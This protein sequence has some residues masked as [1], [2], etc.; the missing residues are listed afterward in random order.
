MRLSE[1][2]A[3]GEP[4]RCAARR[5]RGRRDPRALASRLLGV[6]LAVA[7]AALGSGARAQP[8]PASAAAGAAHRAGVG[9]NL[10]GWAYFSPDF[11]LI[12]QFKRSSG[13]LTQCEPSRDARCRDFAP[14]A[15]PWDT[16]EQARLE[17]DAQ[18]WPRRL[19]AA[20]DPAT[21]FRSV[22]VLL[23][24]GN[25]RTHPK[26]RYVV[27][28][29]GKG[30]LVHDLAGRKIERESRPGRDVVEVSDQ[31]DGG[32]RIAITA[33]DPKDPLR[34][35]RVVPPGGVCQKAPERYVESAAGCEPRAD[36]AFVPFD[37][38]PVDRLWHPRFVQ[39]LRGFRVL[40]FMDWGQTNS[41][42]LQH[43]ADRP[44]PDDAHWSGPAGVPLEAML[45]LSRATAAD[46]W[47]N[48]PMR[49]SDDYVRGF[50]RLLR[51]RLPPGRV[52]I[53]E[54]ANEP[55]N[56]AFPVAAWMRQQALARW[57]GAAARAGGED[58]LAVNWY[59][60]RSARLCQMV[61]AEWG[62]Q[63]APVRCV[64]NGHAAN[65]DQLRQMLACPQAAAELG[66]PCAK[67]VD[68]LAVAPYFGGYLG[69]P[70]IRP[71][72]RG[73]T[74]DADGGLGRLFQ[75]LLAEDDRR[76]PVR[77]PLQ[78]LHRDAPAGGALAQSHAWMRS[79]KA[80]ADAFGLPLWAYE[81]GQHL[82]MPPGVDDPAWLALIT[83]ANRDPRMARAYERSLAD[84][85]AAGGQL[86]VW[87]NH[88]AT[89][90]RWGAW[91]L[92]ETPF[93]E[94]AVKWQ[95][96]RAMRDQLACWWPRCDE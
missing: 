48:L 32:W 57:P 8:A 65:P 12:D 14:G 60:W 39:D 1:G 83:A 64:L 26:G 42:P 90:S 76:A 87:F 52:A 19:P 55:W 68:A 95:A 38:W 11:P 61:K 21:R 17:L 9:L 28:Y 96:V 24:N 27:T 16:R 71:L 20:D 69:E 34:N 13:W 18:G 77:P 43:W 94:A 88:M 7:L 53:V 37:H 82:T 86:L 33:T 35:I 44:K 66:A 80:Q 84:W 78:G 75:E 70:A 36:G 63:P 73:W 25:G 58:A 5:L 47:L 30:T 3:E 92:K 31:A 62:G 59:A 10:A 46:P 85:R 79:A 2:L 40:R 6:G 22:A 56:Q 51:E 41:S 74:Q 23:F 89:P 29:T 4:K 45:E 72:V 91:G 54:Y 50:A 93:S 67:S 81:A 49:A 15:G